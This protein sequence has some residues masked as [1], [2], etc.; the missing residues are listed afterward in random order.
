M[1]KSKRIQKII[2]PCC[3]IMLTLLLFCCVTYTACKKDNCK[4]ISCKNNGVC[5][6]GV[7]TCPIPFKGGSCETELRGDYYGIYTGNGTDS[8]GDEYTGWKLKC[9]KAG[10]DAS[11]MGLDILTPG[12]TLRVAFIIQLQSTTSFNIKAQD[13]SATKISGS[14]TFGTKTM[15]LHITDSTNALTINFDNMQKI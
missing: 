8:H 12:D 7:C 15:S 4:N 3:T 1:P 6:D 14:G 13:S 5:T 2:V 11:M 10:T 9:Y